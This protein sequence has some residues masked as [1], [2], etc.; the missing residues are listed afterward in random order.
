M[1][2]QLPN[3]GLNIGTQGESDWHL[4]LN[5]NFEILDF[6]FVYPLEYDTST[7]QVTV[8][9]AGLS[10]PNSRRFIATIEDLDNEVVVTWTSGEGPFADTDFEV[11]GL[12]LEKSSGAAWP[13]FGVKPGSKTVNGFTIEVETPPGTGDTY[14]FTGQAIREPD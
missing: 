2:T 8:D 7:N 12:V 3:L 13:N 10:V 1:P 5:E 6:L 9:L 4:F 11:V 14:R